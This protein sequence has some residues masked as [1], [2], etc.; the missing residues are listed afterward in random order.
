L[1]QGTLIAVCLKYS[2]KIS[3]NEY[4]QKLVEF[5]NEEYK[6]FC[7]Y[8]LVKE[9]SKFYP[10][11]T[12]ILRNGLEGSI[13]ANILRRVQLFWTP[14]EDKTLSDYEKEYFKKEEDQRR[15]YIESIYDEDARKYLEILDN[16][17]KRK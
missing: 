7:S 9:I 4:A 5:L 6:D 14:E 10:G 1:R 15:E 3:W 17:I 12:L 13:V 2:D 8:Y 16:Y 11:C